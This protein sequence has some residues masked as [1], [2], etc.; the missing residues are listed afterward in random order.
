MKTMRLVVKI[1]ILHGFSG[2]K[3]RNGAKTE[4][5]AKTNIDIGRQKVLHG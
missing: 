1:L 5:I 3:P 2:F 4:K